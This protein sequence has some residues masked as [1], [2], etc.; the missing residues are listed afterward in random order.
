MGYETAQTPLQMAAS[1]SADEVHGALMRASEA[2]LAAGCYRLSDRPR[3]RLL[4]GSC[5][6]GRLKLRICALPVNSLQHP[7]TGVLAVGIRS[8]LGD[9]RLNIGPFKDM[10]NGSSSGPSAAM[11]ESYASNGQDWG[12]LYRPQDGLDGRLG[13]AHPEGFR[14]TPPTTAPSGHP[15]PERPLLPRAAVRIPKHCVALP[16]VRFIANVV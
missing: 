6:A 14:C 5:R 8:G 9:E 10:T 13:R 2:S 16:G 15:L 12:I 11:R 3:L 4:L 1:P 7:V